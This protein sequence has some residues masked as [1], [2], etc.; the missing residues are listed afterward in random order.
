MVWNQPTRIASKWEVAVP[1]VMGF[2]HKL[3]AAGS[4]V[5][6]AM[7]WTAKAATGP[8]MW[9]MFARGKSGSLLGAVAKRAIGPGI[10]IG[11][12]GLMSAGRNL[13]GGAY[14]QASPNVA[15][16]Y[17]PGVTTP[18]NDYTMSFSH[19]NI[20]TQTMGATGALNFALHNQRKR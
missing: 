14:S 5:M 19:G 8:A 18:F 6:G 11:A 15:R 7:K 9:G 12:F 13:I 2:V 1:G 4:S 16:G 10:L 20:S 3:G 17:T